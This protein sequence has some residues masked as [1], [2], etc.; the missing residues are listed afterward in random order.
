MNLHRLDPENVILNPYEHVISVLGRCLEEFD[1]DNMIP[2]FGFGD[3]RTK[4]KSV[5]GF[6]ND[7]CHG[8]EEVLIRYRNE[9]NDIKLSG[10]TTFH[11][12]I[13]TA[14]SI[15][16][17]EE[18]Y[19]ILVI[20]CDGNIDK[21]KN[22]DKTIASIIEASAAAPLSIICVGVGDGPFD[23]MLEF[24]DQLPLRAFD[25]FQF[26]EF[27]KTWVGKTEE[28]KDANFAMHCLMEVPEQYLFLKDSEAHG[29]A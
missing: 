3:V 18:S 24:D 20:I 8:F 28:E 25:N 2:V 10:G 9:I 19:H 23:D 17:S 6:G 22:K 26:V 16:K 4:E 27:S 5:V 11:P 14:A 29:I 1:D 15:A 13:N 7:K 12:I 21:K